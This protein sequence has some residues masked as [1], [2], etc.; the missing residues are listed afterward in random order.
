M[1]FWTPRNL[2]PRSHA[3]TTAQPVPG[4]H[5]SFLLPLATG[6]P[7]EGL[8]GAATFRLSG[9]LRRLLQR[10][11]LHQVGAFCGAW[12]GGVSF[13]LT[14]SYTGVWALA[15]GLGLLAAALHWPISEPSEP[16]TAQA[17]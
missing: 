4:S 6:L 15:A 10:V 11:K 1:A 16:E 7:R 12:L 3:R 14:G 9:R 17:V 2:R 5:P 13:D 8:G